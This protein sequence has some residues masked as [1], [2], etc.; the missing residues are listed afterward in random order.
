MPDLLSGL[1]IEQGS[2]GR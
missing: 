1:A 2:G